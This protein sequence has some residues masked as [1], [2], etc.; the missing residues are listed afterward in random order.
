MCAEDNHWR[1]VYQDFQ[2]NPQNGIRG[3]SMARRDV[4]VEQD[5]AI[6]GIYADRQNRQ[7]L[8]YLRAIS[9]RMPNEV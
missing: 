7:I 6:S 8:Q 3:K 4:Y 2:N 5:A 9:N 1:M